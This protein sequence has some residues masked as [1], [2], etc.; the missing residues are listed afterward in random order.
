MSYGALARGQ[1]V[2]SIPDSAALYSEYQRQCVRDP[3]ACYYA[4]LHLLHADGV[5]LDVARARRMQKDLCELGLEVACL[6]RKVSFASSFDS[7]EAL[8][9]E[10]RLITEHVRLHEPWWWRC[11]L[12]TRP[13]L[14]G[15][16][17]VLVFDVNLQ[18]AVTGARISDDGGAP[19]SVTRCLVNVAT[20]VRFPPSLGHWKHEIAYPMTFRD[21][22]PNYSRRRFRSR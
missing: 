4:S 19:D 21:L 5:E 16:T 20:S 15:G 1:Q 8:A 14:F 9:V 12:V 3:T 2:E 11:I 6:A 17:V 7:K 10:R 13:P 18:G 22:R